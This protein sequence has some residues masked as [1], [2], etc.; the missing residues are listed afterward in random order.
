MTIG[1][2]GPDADAGPTAR[3][4][5]G[6]LVDLYVDGHATVPLLQAA[7]TNA[8]SPRASTPPGGRR[9]AFGDERKRDPSFE[10][11][12]PHLDSIDALQAAGFADFCERLWGPVFGMCSEKTL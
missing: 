5:L 12:A 9:R 11:A 6:D 10:L 8:A 1:P 4:L 7:T 3:L 2:V